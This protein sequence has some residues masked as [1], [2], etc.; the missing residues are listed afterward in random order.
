[1]KGLNSLTRSTQKN[2][3]KTTCGKPIEVNQL[4]AIFTGFE[5]SSV[6][7]CY[8]TGTNQMM[9]K[10]SCSVLSLDIQLVTSC[11]FEGK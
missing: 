10:T 1:M 5:D 7:S 8:F 6:K 4:I 9:A 11:H 2:K 3:S